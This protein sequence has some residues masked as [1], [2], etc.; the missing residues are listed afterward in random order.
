LLFFRPTRNPKEEIVVAKN[1]RVDSGSQVINASYQAKEPGT[2]ILTWDN[3]FSWMTG[4]TLLYRIDMATCN[5][6][7]VA[8]A[9]AAA[10]S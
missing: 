1:A 6:S 3:S 10:S 8:A 7:S 2:L 9:A 4:K 5:P